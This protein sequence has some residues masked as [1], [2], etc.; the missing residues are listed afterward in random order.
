MSFDLWNIANLDLVFGLLSTD[1]QTGRRALAVVPSLTEEIKNESAGKHAAAILNVF[2]CWDPNAT[3][4]KRTHLSSGRTREPAT[5]PRQTQSRRGEQLQLEC[6][7]YQA[8]KYDRDLILPAVASACFRAAEGD[9][10]LQTSVWPGKLFKLKF[11]RP[12]A[13]VL[14]P[15]HPHAAPGGCHLKVHEGVIVLRAPLPRN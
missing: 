11:P 3:L 4:V 2:A 15:L 6:L 14:H 7:F 5:A 10:R 9:V 8:G 13:A 12:V 1:G